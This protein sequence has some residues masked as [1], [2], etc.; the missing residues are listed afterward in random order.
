VR[1]DGTIDSS[2]L[3]DSVSVDG[4]SFLLASREARIIVTSAGE[5]VLLVPIVDAINA[6]GGLLDWETTMYRDLGVILGYIPQTAVP[7]TY[8]DA[9]I[10]TID[11]RQVL[12]GEQVVLVY[13]FGTSELVIIAPS[14]NAFIEA[15]SVLKQ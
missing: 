13:G 8:V 11:T 14:T 7:A 6:R 4:E 9:L 1:A 5:R 12:D 10:G 2:F 15:V 3:S